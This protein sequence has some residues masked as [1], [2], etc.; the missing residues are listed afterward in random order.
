MGRKTRKE[1]EFEKEEDRQKAR[2]DA[3][4]AA[5]V[6]CRGHCCKGFCLSSGGL[7]RV[8]E[9]AASE[10]PEPD[11]V[12]LAKI[13]VPIGYYDKSPENG[14]M[15]VDPD[16]EGATE[17]L[18]CSALTAEGDC[19]IYDSRPQM[20]QQYPNWGGVCQYDSCVGP[21]RKDGPW[22]LMLRANASV[23]TLRSARFR[24]LEKTDLA[25]LSKALEKEPEKTLEAGDDC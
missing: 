18:T 19:S 10:E 6:R 24:R 11:A 1:R 5:G 17:M 4:V 7:K 16:I 3:E 13:L 22:D 8:L 23:R 15:P 2:Y 21:K 20:C 12:L 9:K 25:G 14:G